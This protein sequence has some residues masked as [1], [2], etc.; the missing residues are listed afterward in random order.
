MTDRTDG[1]A[2]AILAVAE[3]EGQVDVVG[4]ELARLGRAIEGSDEL[5]DA[6]SDASIPVERRLG[7]VADLLGG[8]VSET[9]LH[10]ASLVVGMG[11]GAEL[12]SIADRLSVR[13]AERRGAAVAEVRA[14]MEL[15][16]ETL[17]RIAAALSQR[18]GRPVETR[19]VVDP[20]VV[21]GFVATVGDVVI[22]ASV[23][24]RLDE[25]GRQL[26]RG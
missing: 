25:V 19:L 2:D 21:G 23:K 16:E 5:R 8:K 4:S 26:V 3:A 13:A 1:Y 10:L 12:G 22:D 24:R 11:R 20:G 15:D 6:L 9:T 7:V 18:I 17:A 14:A